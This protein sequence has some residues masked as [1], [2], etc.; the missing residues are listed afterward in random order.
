MVFGGFAFHHPL[1]QFPDL[2]F[3]PQ[4]DT[5]IDKIQT[6]N[7]DQKK[8][9]HFSRAHNKFDHGLFPLLQPNKWNASTS[10]VRRELPIPFLK[11]F[12]LKHFW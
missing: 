11:G 1:H 7:H 10:N 8:G 6:P 4:P 5:S 12:H 2:K 9:Q 3:I